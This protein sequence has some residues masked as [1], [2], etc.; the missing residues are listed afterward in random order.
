MKSLSELIDLAD[1]GWP[2]RAAVPMHELWSLHTQMHEQIRDL[3]DG[4]KIQIVV[5]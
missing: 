3:P 4:A 2:M 1:P 5:E